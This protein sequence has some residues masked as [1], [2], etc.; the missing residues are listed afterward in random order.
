MRL[1]VLAAMVILGGF[2]AAALEVTFAFWGPPSA[3]LIKGVFDIATAVQ[4][5]LA[6]VFGSCAAVAAWSILFKHRVAVVIALVL[7][8]ATGALLP[9]SVTTTSN[10][11]RSASAVGSMSIAV[12]RAMSVPTLVSSPV[13]SFGSARLRTTA[14]ARPHFRSCRM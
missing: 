13:R 1:L 4:V 3:F 6:G 7:S 8:A 9:S 11:R 10:T 12:F 2:V 5:L 14:F